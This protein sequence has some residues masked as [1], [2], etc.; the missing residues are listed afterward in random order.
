MEGTN[1][2]I[3]KE[4]HYGILQIL[5]NNSKSMRSRLKKFVHCKKISSEYRRIEPKS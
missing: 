4:K 1:A 2:V 3:F 5:S